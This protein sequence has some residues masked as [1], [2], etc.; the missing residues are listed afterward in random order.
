[1]SQKLINWFNRA[2]QQANRI[3]KDPF[4]PLF[5]EF[6]A[7]GP[8]PRR[9][10]DPLAYMKIDEF[11]PKVNAEL[12]RLGVLELP[13]REQIGP[14]YKV[15]KELFEAEPDEVQQQIRE[16]A[17]EEHEAALQEHR[18]ATSVSSERTDQEREKYV[19]AWA[20]TLC[21]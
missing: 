1:M 16:A 10:Q 4:K 9:L 8:T 17:I 21:C 15:A 19:P 14:R 11:A 7:P 2:R 18:E 6:T 5:N 20:Y 13:S 3:Q 12:E